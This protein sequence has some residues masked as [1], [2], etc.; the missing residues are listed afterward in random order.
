[1]KGFKEDQ[2][3]EDRDG[4]TTRAAAIAKRT[5]QRNPGIKDRILAR[6]VVMGM[7]SMDSPKMKNAWM[8]LQPAERD[9]VVNSGISQ[10]K[11]KNV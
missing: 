7:S 4:L 1:M 6:M 11:S 2:L 10:S 3:A 8:K 9:A 5:R